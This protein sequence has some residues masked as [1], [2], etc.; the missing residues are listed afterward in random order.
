M[1]R[2]SREEYDRTVAM[3]RAAIRARKARPRILA[4]RNPNALMAAILEKHAKGEAPTEADF[5]ALA[6]AMAEQEART[7]RGRGRPKGTRD[8]AAL[9]ALRAAI[10]AVTES[11]L[12]P[13]RNPFAPALSQCDAIA[14][15]MRLEEFRRM[16]SYDAAKREML[17]RG[18]T[19]KK[20]GKLAA[21]YVRQMENRKRDLA[22][23]IG[24]V[25]RQLQEN[26]ALTGISAETRRAFEIYGK[27]MR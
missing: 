19:L 21:E 9:G 10:W 3:A 25:M 6:G 18:R 8:T 4:D 15:A 23:A 14:E 2:Y 27:T 1:N 24:P 13:Y 16:C 7:Q 11:G 20:I 5:A 22:E 12:N 26:G 17:A